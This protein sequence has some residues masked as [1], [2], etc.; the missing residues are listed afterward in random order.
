MVEKNWEFE[1]FELFDIFSLRE[2]KKKIQLSFNNV[3]LVAL[4]QFLLTV[5]R[6]WQIYQEDKITVPILFNL[7]GTLFV[8][9]HQQGG[10]KIAFRVE[11][12]TATGVLLN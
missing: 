9:L 12:P 5:I 10:G 3:S 7:S 8:S 4:N 1:D 11:Q 6:F 2:K